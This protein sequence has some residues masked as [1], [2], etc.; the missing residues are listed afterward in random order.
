LNPPGVVVLSGDET[1]L[2]VRELRAAIGAADETGRSVEYA[3]GS[4]RDE[5]SR[6]LSSTG[7]FFQQDVLLVVER[8]EP[9]DSSLVLAH[10][11]RGSNAVCLLLYHEGKIKSGTGLAKVA[12]GLPARLVAKFDKPKPWEEN[13]RAVDFCLA[14]AARRKIRLSES[15]SRGIVQYVGTDLGMLT[16][17]IEKLSML[18]SAESRQEATQKDVKAVLGAFSELGPK[19]VVDAL[20]RR[21]PKALGHALASVRRTHAGNLGGAT[22]RT[23]AFV[24]NA[25]ATWLHVVA[26]D[27]EGANLE[28][29]ATRVNKHPFLVRKTL[30]PVAKRWGEG[31]LT[32][33]LKSIARVER[34]VKVGHLSP[35]VQLECALLNACRPSQ[36]E[37]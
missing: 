22:L 7:V 30:L 17:E 24:S 29:V 37:R 4:S 10:H 12:D 1:F 9:V 25:A 19:P 28:E 11:E 31:G 13:E 34:S 18:L 8:P 15:L 5:I 27:A 3:E 6:V 35:W 33:L 21:D 32:S 26:L 20:E 14:E 36:G 23:C 2:R 16:F